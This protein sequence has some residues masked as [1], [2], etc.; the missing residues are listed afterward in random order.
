MNAWIASLGSQSVSSNM[1]GLCHIY[2]DFILKLLLSLTKKIYTG[3]KIK[4]KYKM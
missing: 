2:A 3:L 4:C 1:S